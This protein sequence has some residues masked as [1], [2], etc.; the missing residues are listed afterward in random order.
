MRYFLMA[1]LLIAG[2]AYVQEARSA[3]SVAT[4]G[5]GLQQV[6]V[7]GQCVTYG[8]SLEPSVLQFDGGFRVFTPGYEWLIEDNF[9]KRDTSECRRYYG[10][11][12][13]ITNTGVVIN[14]VCGHDDGFTIYTEEYS[15]GKE[16]F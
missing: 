13:F 10:S 15:E 9:K 5:D 6:C 7:S 3:V 8:S 14:R 4:I 12:K 16:S 2:L 1:A 11:G